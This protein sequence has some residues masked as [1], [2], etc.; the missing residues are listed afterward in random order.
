VEESSSASRGPPPE[1][2]AFY[3]QGLEMGRLE[4]GGGVLEFARTQEMLRG[5]LQPGSRVLDVGGGPGVHAAWLAADGHSVPLV[6]PVPLHV[7]QAREK[8]RGRFEVSQGDA[9]ALQF[10]DCSF[11]AV[12]LLGPLYHLPERNDRV[13]ALR[14]ACRV[15]VPGGFVAAAA[16][17]RFAGL[18]D[19]LRKGWLAK[20]ELVPMVEE[21]LASGRHLS[22]P[23]S[24]LFTTAFFH[25]AEEFEREVADAGLSKVAV[26]G[27]EGPGGVLPDLDERWGDP[28][29]REA[30]L[31][32]ARGTSP[33][34]AANARQ[35]PQGSS[36]SFPLKSRVDVPI[37][38][39]NG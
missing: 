8:A 18:I 15:L 38:I 20:E 37:D 13:A 4:L 36:C 34:A 33:E 25:L 29:F 16:I 5:Y 21:E 11:D 12:L 31:W 24:D 1:V 3:A 26:L 14:E 32:A 39:V 27:I 22:P 30:A 23:D 2:L 9:L 6:D 19:G 28:H 17:S 7:Q 10:D 35:S